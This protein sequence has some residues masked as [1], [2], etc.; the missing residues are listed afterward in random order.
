MKWPLVS[1][2][3]YDFMEATVVRLQSER[4]EQQSRA[5]R[6]ADQLVDRM[7]FQ[8]V[9][10]PVRTEMKEAM[11]ELEKYVDA[12]QF[13]DVGSG[14]ISPDVLELVEYLV[15]PATKPV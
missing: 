10:A 14:M 15:D 6:L 4:D 5:D 7:G 9:S 8:P 2:R 1:R 13:E 12:S 3:A 11:A